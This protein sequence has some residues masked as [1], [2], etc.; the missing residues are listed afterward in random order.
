[1]LSR[2]HQHTFS[3]PSCLIQETQVHLLML[4]LVLAFVPAVL[5]IIGQEENVQ[6]LSG[7]VADVGRNVKMRAPSNNRNDFVT[8]L[9]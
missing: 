9:W 3:I 2:M 7:S 1:M 6:R 8:A 5:F 4:K